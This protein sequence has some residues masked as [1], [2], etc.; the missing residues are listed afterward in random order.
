MIL[1]ATCLI[2]ARS[3]VDSDASL[4]EK[5]ATRHK[6]GHERSRRLLGLACCVCLSSRKREK[7]QDHHRFFGDPAFHQ[8]LMFRLGVA[9]FHLQS[10]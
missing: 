9:A 6:C 4:G 5:S 8:G 1:V 10:L 2:P 3:S 7:K